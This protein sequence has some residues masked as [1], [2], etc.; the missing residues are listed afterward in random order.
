[1]EER[2]VLNL[3]VRNSPI[4]ALCSSVIHEWAKGRFDVVS[5]VYCG[6]EEIDDKLNNLHNLICLADSLGIKLCKKRE[7]I[8]LHMWPK[9]GLLKKISSLDGVHVTWH[10]LWL[11]ETQYACRIIKRYL[12]FFKKKWIPGYRVAYENLKYHPEWIDYR[13]LDDFVALHGADEFEH[14]ITAYLHDNPDNDF[15]SLGLLNYYDDVFLRRNQD[16]SDKTGSV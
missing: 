4:G 11:S 8:V 16:D 2:K 12:G 15:Y 10:D 7:V 1:M 3:F 13:T 14:L 5:V 6:K 9:K